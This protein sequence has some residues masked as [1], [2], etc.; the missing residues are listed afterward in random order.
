MLS[1]LLHFQELVS[2]KMKMMMCSKL[3]SQWATGFFGNVYV[4]VVLPTSS[5]ILGSTLLSPYK[6][7][8]CTNSLFRSGGRCV[9]CSGTISSG[10]EL[11][12]NQI[13]FIFQPCKTIRRESF[14]ILM[15]L[16]AF[17]YLPPR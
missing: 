15:L 4:F 13:F 3:V 17:K 8:L 16:N 6:G 11:E 10:S 2:G 7:A 12:T 14:I 9:W 1:S 5:V